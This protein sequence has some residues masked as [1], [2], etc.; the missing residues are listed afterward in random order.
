MLLLTNFRIKDAPD[1][2][3]LAPMSLDEAALGVASV[4][5]RRNIR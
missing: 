5:L 4:G 2:P 1:A 3:A